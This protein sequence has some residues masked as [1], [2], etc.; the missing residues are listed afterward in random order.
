MNVSEV[1][2]FPRPGEHMT[3]AE[4]AEYMS[5]LLGISDLGGS[6]ETGTFDANNAE[7][8]LRVHLPQKISAEQFAD[9]VLGF[10]SDET[11]STY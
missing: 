1:L 7:Q 4:L 11:E 5:T 9:Q 8:L 3:E 10:Y 6:A 2:F